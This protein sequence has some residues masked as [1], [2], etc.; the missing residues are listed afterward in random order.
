MRKVYKIMNILTSSVYLEWDVDARKEE[1][2]SSY[3]G[4]NSISNIGCF[5]CFYSWTSGYSY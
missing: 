5:K 2:F 3:A 1:S 4:N